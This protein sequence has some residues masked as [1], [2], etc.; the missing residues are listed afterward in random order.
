M[1]GGVIVVS[2]QMIKFVIYIM[3][4]T[5]TFWWDD[6]NVYF[7]LGKHALLNMLG[8]LVFNLTFNNISV[9][10]WQVSRE[11]SDVSMIPNR[12]QNIYL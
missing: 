1:S 11:S 6:D 9:T 8:L 5:V 10:S 12:T 2:G 4:N 3:I 7:V